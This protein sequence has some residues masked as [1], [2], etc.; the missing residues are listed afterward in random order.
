MSSLK[1]IKNLRLIN[2]LHKIIVSY[3]T[4]LL[5]IK[6]QTNCWPASHIPTHTLLQHLLHDFSQFPD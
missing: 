1:E 2:T 6:A 3:F 4:L 5:V